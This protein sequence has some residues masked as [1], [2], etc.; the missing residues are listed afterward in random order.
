MWQGTDKKKEH[1]TQRDRGIDIG[2]G[3]S[4][5]H[6]TVRLASHPPKVS[7]YLRH[8][9]KYIAVSDTISARLISNI[10]LMERYVKFAHI[11]MLQIILEKHIFLTIKN[12]LRSLKYL[13]RTVSQL[14]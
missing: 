3:E 9:D 8:D 13:S 1:V 12:L 5:I 2:S 14:R 6:N 11:E 4:F 7:H 10:R